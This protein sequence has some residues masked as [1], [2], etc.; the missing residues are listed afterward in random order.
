[1]LIFQCSVTHTY[2]ECE[3]LVLAFVYQSGLN[4]PSEKLDIA[5]IKKCVQNVNRISP[6]SWVFLRTQKWHEYVHP[7]TEQLSVGNI[8]ICSVFTHCVNCAVCSVCLYSTQMISIMITK[9]LSLAQWNIVILQATAVVKEEISPRGLE[10]RVYMAP[11]AL[12]KRV[13]VSTP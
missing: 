5:Q 7:D 1:M 10:G 2:M 8:N 4:F 3:V 9:Y 12:R 13:E 11:A 6:V